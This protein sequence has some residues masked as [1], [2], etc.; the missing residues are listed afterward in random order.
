[1]ALDGTDTWILPEGLRPDMLLAALASAFGI[2]TFP[3]Y[4][5]EVVYTD[6]FDWRLFQDGFLL[7]CHNRSWT[8]YHGDGGE[9]TVQQDGPELGR[10][11]FGRDFPPGPLR[12]LL[13]PVLGARALLPMARVHLIGR[14]VRL[15]NNDEKTVARLVFERQRPS[16]GTE[17][18]SLVRLFGLR[19]FD[20]ELDTVRC[21]LR[22]NGVTR[23]ASPLVGFEEACRSAGRRP[24]DY[25][26]KF[27]VRLEPSW[28]AREA[29]VHIYRQLLAIISR[30]LSGTID[31]LDPEFL[32]DL[33]VAIRRTRSGLSLAKDVLPVEVVETARRD[34]AALG[35]ITGPTRDLDVYLENCEIYL[36]RLP[37]VLR[38]GLTGFFADLAAR[39][40]TEQHRMARE[41]RAKKTKTILTAWKRHLNVKEPPQAPRADVPVI[42][43]A[44]RIIHRR[45]KRVLRDGRAL[46][47]ATP[48]EDVHRLRI[49]CKKLRYALEF[50]GSLYP[51]DEMALLVRQLKRLQ[52]IIGDFNDLSVQQRLLATTLAGMGNGSRADL[53]R[54]AALGALMQ[55][56]YQEQ[57]A[58]RDHLSE[59]FARFADP[60]TVHLYR[61]LFRPGE[62]PA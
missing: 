51:E 29:M 24:L 50:F 44:G 16:A 61:S 33:R 48:D 3:E 38:P 9:V 28:T 59:V 20:Q 22:E 45:S 23:P 46:H 19:G 41:L 49:Q 1:M 36:E 27:S 58:L 55:N 12:D 13:I 5:A 21:L 25:S 14:Q 8:L 10:R 4:A 37:E 7:H 2:Q 34:F 53:G 39:R 56:L 47:A 31:D 18:F 40:Q 17:V 42:E 54:A 52:D 6:S 57:Q 32:H 15:L 30:N 11:C 43:L 62:E 35:A 60:N 26:S